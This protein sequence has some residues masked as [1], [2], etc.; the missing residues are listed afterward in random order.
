MLLPPHYIDQRVAWATDVTQ[1][2]RDPRVRYGGT[3]ILDK[4]VEKTTFINVLPPHIQPISVKRE[5]EQTAL[6]KKILKGVGGGDPARPGGP[7]GPV[8]PKVAGE[9]T[10]TISNPRVHSFT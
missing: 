8:H 5:D 2:P 9:V 10:G 1:L 3:I 7:A 4:G 6:L